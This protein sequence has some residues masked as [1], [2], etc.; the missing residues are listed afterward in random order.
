MKRIA[1]I[2]TLLVLAFGLAAESAAQQQVTI[3]EINDVPDEN[4]EQLIALGGSATIEQITELTEPPLLGEEVT[5]TAVVLTRP[6]S[7]GLATNANRIHMF[8]RDVAAETE[9][10]EGMGM[11]V[12]DG[13]LS[14]TSLLIGDIVTMTGVVDR[15]GLTIQFSPSTFEVVGA[16]EPGDPLL[17]PVVISTDDVHVKVADGDPF[18][19]MQFRWENFEALNN[20]YVRFENA[21][22]VN[23]IRAD[24]G[25]PGYLVS[26]P[27]TET[28]VDSYDPSLRYRNDRSPE[29]YPNPPWNTRPAGDPFIPPPAGAFVNLQGFLVAVSSNFNYPGLGQPNGAI[30]SIAP[31]EDDDLEVLSSA[32]VIGELPRPTEVLGE[33]ESFTVSTTIV[34]DP[35]RTIESATLFY[36]FSTGGGEQSVAM[37]NTS[38]DT[39]AATIP[40]APDGAFVSYYI[41]AEDSG[42]F[43]S[44]SPTASY[45]VLFDG[46]TAIE[47]VQRT[48]SGG[49]GNSPF[50]GLTTEMNIEAVVMSDPETGFLI[51]Q[52]DAGLE[53]WSGVFV[54]VTLDIL[55]LGLQRGDRVTISNAT[56]AENF[57]V[58]ELQDATLERTGS[59]EPYAYKLLPTGVLAQDN[60]T[61]ESYEGMALRFEEVH[62]TDVNADGP[63]NPGPDDTN[64]GE[65]QITNGD[66]ANEV[67]VD[68][69]SATFPTNWNVENLNKWDRIEYVQGMW[70]YSFGNYKLLPESLDDIGQITVDAEDDAVAGGFALEAAYP[71]PFAAS[72]T[73]RFTTTEQSVV[74]LE[75]FDLVGRR[76]ATLVDGPLAPATHT[77]TLD[78]RGLAGGTYLVRLQAGDRV[79]TQKLVLVK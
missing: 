66:A 12:V 60:A 38:G 28:L 50:T 19:R 33:G 21:Q 45:R 35:E 77:V 31:F 34:P 36:T 7:S 37:T 29:V 54:Q 18:D 1:T 2:C 16:V 75:V 68:D 53:P 79:A 69:A 51:I 71:N 70:Y 3:R 40:P 23:S 15:F 49:P 24:A 22:V 30:Y 46:I 25:R 48:V 41:R 57:N 52:D 47:H 65:F 8:V 62:V 11:Q 4:I 5:I 6:Y 42:G 63:D 44:T 27:D 61:A 72:T 74:R 73:L 17:E 14:V 13:S 59:G 56:I 58:T 10:Y 76:V 78:G 43:V 32:P 64:H 67:R 20:Q 26:S 9:G 55:N 39:Y